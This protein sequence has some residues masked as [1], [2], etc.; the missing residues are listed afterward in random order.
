MSLLGKLKNVVK[1]DRKIDIT[2]KYRLELNEIIIEGIKEADQIKAIISQQKETDKEGKND[3]KSNQSKTT[4]SNKF[5]VRRN[6][7]SRDNRRT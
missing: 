1:N 2:E 4:E 3:R 7:N 6:I 5:N